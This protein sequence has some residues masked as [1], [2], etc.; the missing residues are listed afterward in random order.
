[1]YVYGSDSTEGVTG[2]RRERGGEGLKRTFFTH[3][4]F[5][6]NKL[7]N[8]AIFKKILFFV[9]FFAKITKFHCKEYLREKDSL[10][11]SKGGFEEVLSIEL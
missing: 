4:R 9:Q 10:F 1:M 6:Y 3:V 7:Q 11:P 8:A 2:V 5:R